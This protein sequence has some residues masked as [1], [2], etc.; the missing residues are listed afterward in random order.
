MTYPTTT[1]I[2]FL[3]VVTGH[4]GVI[5]TSADDP[6]DALLIEDLRP[7]ELDI[8][9]VLMDMEDAFGVEISDDEADP[10]TVVNGHTGKTL[11]DLLALVDRK[12]AGKAVA[13]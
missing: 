10:F 5:E 4:F 11:R 1:A 12:V 7:D 9:E 6:L 2:R 3:E 8:V 13:A